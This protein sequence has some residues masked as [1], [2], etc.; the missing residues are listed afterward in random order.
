MATC[1]KDV[2]IGLELGAVVHDEPMRVGESGRPAAGHEPDAGT[3]QV[4]GELLLLVKLVDGALGR[5]QQ[6]REVERG[7]WRRQPVVG[8]LLRVASQPRRL[9]K[10]ASWRT[11]VVG[12]GSAG[13]IALDERHARAELG[14]AQRRGDAGRAAADH[15]EVE[16]ASGA[17]A[18]WPHRKPCGTPRLDQV[19]RRGT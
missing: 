1:G 7:R 19:S 8:E 11:S 3:L 9:G 13:L 15:R 2:P 18:H 6:F 10:D 4:A 17:R 12:A 16:G 5:R 14:G